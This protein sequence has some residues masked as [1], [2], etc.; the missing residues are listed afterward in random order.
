YLARA[1]RAAA[2]SASF[3]QRVPTRLVAAPFSA[4]TNLGRI[5]ARSCGQ[6]SATG[7]IS[8]ALAAGGAVVGAA[9]AAESS[10]G[11]VRCSGRWTRDRRA[12]NRDF[13]QSALPGAG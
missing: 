9:V 5:F 4:T 1:A 8:S 3:P 12:L 10:L 2:H 13:S 6:T 11:V 7:V